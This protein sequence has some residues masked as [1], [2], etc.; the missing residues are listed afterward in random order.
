[1]NK[2]LVCTGTRP[3]V[4]KMQSVYHGLKKYTNI[5]TLLCYSGQHDEMGTQ[6]LE[7]F[8]LKPDYLFKLDQF[9]DRTL[10]WITARL[11]ENFSDYFSTIKPSMV[12]SHGDNVTALT[13]S[14]AAYYLKIP[15][16]HVEAGLRTSRFEYPN[17]EEGI[18]RMISRITTLHFAP[19]QTAVSNLL[20]EGITRNVYLTGNTVIDSLTYVLEESRGQMNSTNSP[21]RIVLVTC[22]R[23]E[24]WGIP[25]IQ[26]CEILKKFISLNPEYQIIF[27]VHPNPS[28][29]SIIRD[30][31]SGL[32]NIC[33]YNSIEYPK[34]VKMMHEAQFIIT[35]SGGVIEE[36]S[37]LGRPV[38]ILR[39]E[40]ERPEALKLSN[41]ELVGYDYA[42]AF[43]IMEKW[44]QE[45]P[46]GSFTNLYGTG[47]AGTS[48]AEIISK[49]LRGNNV[50][51]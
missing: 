3:D 22:H 23:R 20:D 7:V 44:A 27:S 50:K 48:I 5:E 36:A 45:S 17:P 14:I 34:F 40:I 46:K 6:M 21:E 25:L 19:T 41:V 11:I 26:L 49:Y 31:L 13:A 37:T 47:Q 28:V 10:G 12:L 9:E 32:H 42:R 8:N 35:D 4:I 15:V 29:S 38:L 24:N 16:G 30:Q 2:V 51:H 33:L 1:M 43:K 18:R 39:D